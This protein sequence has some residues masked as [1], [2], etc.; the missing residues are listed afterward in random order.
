MKYI[1]LIALAIGIS[2][3][4]ASPNYYPSTT[5]VESF[6]S[7]GCG[8]CIT[9]V[10]GLDIL[11]ADAHNGELLFSRLYTQSGDYSSPEIDARFSHYEVMG[12]P[13]VI[14]DGKT[15]VNGGGEGIADGSQYRAALKKHRHLGSPL[16]MEVS[17]FNSSSGAFAGTV[18]MMSDS[19][20]VINATLYYYLL[21]DNVAEGFTYLVR[22]VQSVPFA[23]TGMGSTESF[24]TTFNINPAWNSANLWA[25]AFVQIEDNAIL[26]SVSTRSVP[27]YDLRVALDWDQHI[28]GQAN[29]TF[30]SETF[31]VFNLGVAENFTRRIEVDSAPLGWSFNYCDEDETCYPGWLDIPLNMSSGGLQAFHFNLGIGDPGIARFRFVVSS[32]NL[33]T[34]SIPFVYQVEGVSNQDLSIPVSEMSVVR[35]FPNPFR[36]RATIEVSSSKSGASSRLEIYNLKGQKVESIALGNV[37]KGLTQI[38]WD[39][40]NLPDGVYLYRMQGSSKSG[41]LLKLR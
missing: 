23:L 2:M 38:Q 35:S 40:T 26:Q 5:L 34:Y 14:F 33:G 7:V 9:S 22:S 39:A 15:R 28:V 13:S 19:A 17:S 12:F 27:E 25:L 32:P 3:L 41:K 31:W 10:Q 16:K 18:Q 11:D 6:G 21:E 8:A 4:F 24:S 20:V 37:S 30:N 29:V 1:Y 36:D